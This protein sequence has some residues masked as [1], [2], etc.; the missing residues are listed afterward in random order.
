[1]IPCLILLENFLSICLP[2]RKISLEVTIYSAN[3]PAD[4]GEIDAPRL[5]LASDRGED[6]YSSECLILIHDSL[7]LRGL[8]GI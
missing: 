1:M 3:M 8:H 2:C 7:H 6:A 4:L 5:L